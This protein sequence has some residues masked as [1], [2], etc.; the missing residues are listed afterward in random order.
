M[1][2]LVVCAFLILLFSSKLGAENKQEFFTWV[3]AQGRIHN[4][5]LKQ[6]KKPKSPKQ[7]SD[8]TESNTQAN[9][10]AGEEYL[11]EEE[12]EAKQEKQRQESPAFFTWVDANGQVYNQLIPAP[13]KAVKKA[14]TDSSE[15]YL[16]DVF[17][18]PLRLKNTAEI[19]CC[20]QQ[21][22]NFTQPL[23]AKR[24]YHFINIQAKPHFIFANESAPAFYFSFQGAKKEASRKL[25]II[26]INSSLKPSI[27]ALDESFKPLYQSHALKGVIQPQNWHQTEQTHFALQFDDA[28]IQY[29]IWY[30]PNFNKDKK[31]LEKLEL[32]LLWQ[33]QSSK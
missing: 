5:P 32:L 29:L 23:Q 12:F 15:A 27:I 30:Y 10:I 17:V 19:D 7:H 1:F 21:H 22:S 3:D 20:Q 26:Q 14:A 13:S 24:S 2:R 33:A 4:S 8:G 28:D 6:K 9:Q 11:S 31:S 16:D 25:D 18:K